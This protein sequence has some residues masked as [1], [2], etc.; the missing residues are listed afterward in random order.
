LDESWHVR[1]VVEKWKWIEFSGHGD[2]YG[3]SSRADWIIGKVCEKTCSASNGNNYR[4]EEVV[5]IKEFH[6]LDAIYYPRFQ[7]IKAD[8]PSSM[9]G[10]EFGLAT[11]PV[12]LH[13]NG[14]LYLNIHYNEVIYD[15]ETNTKG[16]QGALYIANNETVFNDANSN[17]CIA[18]QKSC[19]LPYFVWAEDED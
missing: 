11:L 2:T 14:K 19:E 8:Y 15:Y 18:G 5:P 13:E 7:V 3:L 9:D 17:I 12:L 4:Y 6:R 1:K 10:K 16:W